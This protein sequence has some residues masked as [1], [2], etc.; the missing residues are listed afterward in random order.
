MKTNRRRFIQSAGL[1]TSSVLLSGPLRAMAVDAPAKTVSAGDIVPLGNPGLKV[2]RL[3]LG[4][5]MKG[6]QRASNHTRMGQKKFTELVR[7]AHERGS[8]FFDLA[9]MYGT[10][11]C[12]ADAMAGV[13][14]EEYA[15]TTKIWWNKGGIPEPER[16]DAD[17]V[18][19][20]F[21]KE[22]GTD[23]LDLV[24]LHCVTSAKW[25]AELSKQM[26]LLAGL[27]KQGVI[28][29]HG[30]SCHSLP[31]LQAA[32]KEPWVDSIHARINPFGARMDGEPAVILDVLK[33]ARR[34]GK[35]V[36]GMKLIGEGSFR[37]DVDKKRASIRLALTCGCVDVLLVGCETLAE[38]DEIRS[39]MSE[40]S[41]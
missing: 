12:F 3:S 36:V 33:E 24:L 20:R 30:V 7:G 11:G 14:R 6:G 16:P 9:D 29:S 38:L 17:I 4:T 23:H 18:V 15:F 1:I 19:K 21:L 22:L 13:P 39:L 37:D 32:A 34:N 5:G 2:S 28:R 8:R 41:L 40:V 25:T 10:H 31:A 35:G 26:E 27:K